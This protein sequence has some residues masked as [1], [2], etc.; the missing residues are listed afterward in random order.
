MPTFLRHPIYLFLPLL[1]LAG[2]PLR[3]Q[4]TQVQRLEL[5][6]NPKEN[7][8]YEVTTL[9]RDG[10]LLT[11]KIIDSYTGTALKWQFT[12]YDT[13]LRTRWKTDFKVKFPH[14]PLLSY[15]D[16]EYLYWLFGEPDSERI[17][18][19][20]LALATG[21]TETIEGELRAIEAVS[22][23]RVLGNKAFIAGKYHERSVVVLFSFF[24]KTEKVLPTLY[25]NNLDVTSLDADPANNQMNVI[26]RTYRRGKCQL[27]LKT[28]S[29]EGKLLRDDPLPSDGGRTLLSGRFLPTGNRESLLIGS[30]S[31]NCSDYAQGIYL[32]RLGGEGGAEP[33]RFVE[34]AEMK[35]FFNY[36]KPARQQRVLARIAKRREGGKE[37]RFRY[38]LLVHDLV[39][40]PE[41]FLLVAEAFYP[42]YK[43]GG[44]GNAMYA[45]FGSRNV[46]ARAYDMF[47]YTHAFICSFDRQGKLL[48]DNGFALNDVTSYELE[49]QVQL[50]RYADRIV[51]AYPGG[52]RIHSLVIANNQLTPDERAFELR[53]KDQPERVLDTDQ[54]TLAAW[55]GRHFLAWGIQ[56]VSTPGRADGPREVFF[57]SKL[58]YPMGE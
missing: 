49:E 50:T 52:D 21:D 29:Y 57:L 54:T 7:E 40:T 51:V 25:A 36:L 47:K 46:P 56:R 38:L 31:Q 16:A 45:S 42:Q 9:G 43:P 22:Q 58:E 6:Q 15:T 55:Y 5:E 3:A 44:N 34:F 30:F 33:L 8:Q 24:D 39:P 41:G 14:E 53:P 18:I 2:L 13:D 11:R 27:L 20:R 10:V 4:L 19:L 28:F 48:W 23:F 1:F 26:A 37:A 17:L 32:A 12:R 35:N